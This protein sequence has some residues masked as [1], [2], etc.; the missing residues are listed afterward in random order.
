MTNQNRAPEALRERILDIWFGT[1][2][3]NGD[4]SAAQKKRWFSKDPN[5]DREIREE[6]ASTYVNLALAPSTRPTW[7]AGPRG[8]LAGIIVLDQFSRNMFRDSPAMYS[9]D[10]L[11]RGLSYELIALGYDRKLPVPMRVFSYMPLMHSERLPDQ[12]RCVE[13]FEQLSEELSGNQRKAILGNLD[14]AVQHRDIV[15]RFGR[16]PHRNQ[17]LSRTSTDQ[18][19][20]FLKTPGSGF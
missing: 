6:F 1:L 15:A 19:I 2:D 9:A 3:E 16:F 13:L 7:L 20:E 18:E 14:Y 10:D 4:S 17:I 11:A 5:Y 12:E 8:L